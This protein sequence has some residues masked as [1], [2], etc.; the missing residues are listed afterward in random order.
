MQRIFSRI[1]IDNTH[2]KK[3]GEK[4][5]TAEK[6]KYLRQLRK[7]TMSEVC[8]LAG[9]KSHGNFSDIENGNR[10]L[11]LNTLKR[12]AAALRVDVAFLIS[13][14]T[15]TFEEL[16]EVTGTKL[17]EDVSQFIIEE[18]SLPYLILAKKLSDQ[19]IPPKYVEA[20]IKSIQAILDE[21]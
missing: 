12:I 21:K 4:M 5:N 8:T 20:A 7:M 10:Q 19:N 16:A 2:K 9:I 18:D 17:P 1:I 3:A 14:K 11:S 6:I 15:V 13:E